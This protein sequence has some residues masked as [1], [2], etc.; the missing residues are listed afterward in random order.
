[1]GPL[2]EY[3]PLLLLTIA[4]LVGGAGMYAWR[5]GRTATAH[6]RA[7]VCHAAQLAARQE[8]LEAVLN[9]DTGT[10]FLWDA[11]GVLK[12]YAGAGTPARSQAAEVFSAFND[13]LTPK[14][15]S[16]LS[17]ALHGLQQNGT[18]F[19]FPLFCQDQRTLACHGKPVASG[20]ALSISDVSDAFKE[21][22]T[23]RDALTETM[24]ERDFLRQAINGIPY[25]AW[26]RDKNGRLNWVNDAYCRAVDAASVDAVVTRAEELIDR[27]ELSETDDPGN[28]HRI[29][30][31]VS[32]QRRTLDLFE[33]VTDRGSVGIAVDVTEIDEARDEVRKQLVSQ[34]ASLNLLHTPVAIFSADRNLEFFNQDFAD[35]WGLPP[36]WLSGSPDHGEVLEA[37]RESRRLPEQADFPAWKKKQLGCYTNL[38]DS[39]EEI[40]QL[41]NERTLRVVT[42]ARPQGGLF[43]LYE[44]LTE[45]L[46]LERSLNALSKVQRETINKLQEGVAVFAANGE[47]RLFNPSLL[48][49]WSLTEADLENQPH[50]EEMARL[51]SA[52]VPG[53]EGWD[54]I[55]ARVTGAISDR[56]MW[57]LRIHGNNNSAIDC[58]IVPLPDGGTMLTFT[59]VTDSFRIERALRERNDALETTD[60]MKSE[61]I[62]HI[63]YQ[64][65]TP[66]NSIIGFAEILEHEFFGTLNERQHEYSQGL[67]E[68]SH[69]LLTLVNDVIDLATIEAGHM[70]LSRNAMDVYEVLLSV[71][72]LSRQRARESDMTLMLDC[73]KDIGVIQAD[74]RRIKQVMFN[75]MSNA[76]RFSSSGD[77]IAIGANRLVAPDGR[78]ICQLWVRDKGVGI[79]RNYQTN[80]F[81]PFESRSPKGR[82]QGAG[83]GL[84]LVRSLVELHDGWVDVESELN[85]GTKVICNLPL[86]VTDES[87]GDAINPPLET[88]AIQARP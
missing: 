45:L 4:A 25:P 69:H 52:L 47:L 76:I 2:Q 73:P 81:N 6:W 75:L 63:S 18:G 49:M 41:P 44:D 77:E 87:S 3:I 26:R 22:I 38:I 27:R 1:M 28:L 54:E 15:Q 58:M 72:E 16:E 32:G 82:E 23:L 19:A 37:M 62:T 60:R 21:I 43:I 86:N 9:S 53:M 11:D 65:R 55:K 74:S 57:S 5:Q 35:L 78:E 12:V 88:R 79:D 34:R 36:D 68:A 17:A 24:D 56:E 46:T 39:Q 61:F 48:R 70:S 40:W 84:S 31:V 80:M 14:S 51:Y 29:R 71:R 50:V 67:L 30:T 20:T 64:F 10:L 83:L 42:Q 33:I 59:D 7:Q 13:A 8:I 85:Q 66:L